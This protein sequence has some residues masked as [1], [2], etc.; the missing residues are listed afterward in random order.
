MK[1]G[2]RERL[3]DGRRE[4]LRDERWKKREIER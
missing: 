4:G 3:K 2:R 1:D